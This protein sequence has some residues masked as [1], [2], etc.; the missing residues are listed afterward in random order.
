MGDLYRKLARARVSYLGDFF[1]SY[2]VYMMMGYFV[3]RLFEG[4]VHV[5]K[6]HVR[7]KTANITYALTAD[8]VHLQTHF[9]PKRVVVSCL[10]DTV[11]KFCTG[12]NF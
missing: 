11:A 10:H 2:R 6:V 7:F 9:T 1:I 3:F 4:T 8:P 12:V 5:D